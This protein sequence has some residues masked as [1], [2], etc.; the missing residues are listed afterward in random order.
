MEEVSKKCIKESDCEENG[1]YLS[2]LFFTIT[3]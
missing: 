1:Q 2:V 3:T